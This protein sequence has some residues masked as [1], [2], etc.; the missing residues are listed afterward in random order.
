MKIENHL[1]NVLN[2]LLENG[3][4]AWYLNC[5]SIFLYNDSKCIFR[6][7]NGFSNFLLEK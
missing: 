3:E 2:L 6:K 1:E 5:I 4:L 7:I